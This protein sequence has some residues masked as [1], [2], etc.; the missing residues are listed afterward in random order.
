MSYSGNTI[1]A[2]V[3][4]S[5]VQTVIG[6]ASNTLSALCTSANINKWSK[7]KPIRSSSL[8]ALTSFAGSDTHWGL[9]VPTIAAPSASAPTQYAATSWTYNQ[10]RGSANSEYYRL[11]DFDGYNHAA[12]PM[13]RSGHKKGQTISVDAY[14]NPTQKYSITH[15]SS[16]DTNLC[17]SDFSLDLGKANLVLATFYSAVTDKGDSAVGTYQ[18][19]VVQS[20]GTVA[21]GYDYVNFTLPTVPDADFAICDGLKYYTQVIPYLRY[22]STYYPLPFD[23]DNYWLTTY[24][25]TYKT[26]FS[27]GIYKISYNGS[28]WINLDTTNT[29]PSGWDG[30][31]YIQLQ[32]INSTGSTYTL[33]PHGGSGT[34]QVLF[35]TNA[36]GATTNTYVTPTL[37]D[38]SGNTLSSVTIATGTQYIYLK[39]PKAFSTT[40]AVGTG[41]GGQG[42][43]YLSFNSGKNYVT[44]SSG[45][46]K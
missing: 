21:A 28:T 46:F 17:L 12:V 24:I 31:V 44:Q 13:V 22:N 37:I 40:G 3:S 1:S 20:A 4:F 19:V 36:G 18:G 32:I 38:S 2:P 30:T 39:V 45:T 8:T 35:G 7:R 34:L 43:V 15:L 27:G 25:A 5:D 29:K 11:L 41:T 23:E 16:D 10:P 33:Y 6:D 42:Y 26:K 14:D 9:T